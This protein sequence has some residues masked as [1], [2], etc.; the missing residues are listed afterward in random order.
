LW[1]EWFEDEPNFTSVLVWLPLIFILE[2]VCT[3]GGLY[4]SQ[5]VFPGLDSPY[6][7]G[8]DEFQSRTGIFFYFY[9]FVLGPFLEEIIFRLIPI[10]IVL[11]FGW[12]IHRGWFETYLMYLTLLVVSLFFG[13]I[14]GNEVNIF[15]QG[16]G[17]LVYSIVFL[18]WSGWGRNLIKGLCATTFVHGSWNT[19]LTG[20]GMLAELFR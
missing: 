18:K 3:L 13:Y 2:L 17:G 11:I 5:I 20:G 1:R 8:F 4:L 7:E 9:V 15:I 10:V 14:H 19:L 6:G 12:I 16:V